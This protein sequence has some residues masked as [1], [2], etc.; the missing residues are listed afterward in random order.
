MCWGGCYVCSPPQISEEGFFKVIMVANRMVL[1]HKY[2]CILSVRTDS[3]VLIIIMILGL[4]SGR[5]H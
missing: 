5:I 1:C 2:D 3:R 4:Q